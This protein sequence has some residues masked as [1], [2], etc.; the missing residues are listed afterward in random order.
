MAHVIL[1]AGLGFGDEGKGSMVDH[2]ART[3]KVGTPSSTLV[4][5]Y[6]GGAQAAHNVVTPDGKHHTFAQF[7]SATLA[8]AKTHLSRHMLIEPLSMMREAE[9]LRDLGVIDPFAKMTIEGEALVTNVY[10][11]LANRMRDA[12][13]G[14][15]RHGSCGLGVGETVADAL[16]QPNLALRAKDLFDETALRWKLEASFDRKREEFSDA[17]KELRGRFPILFDALAIDHIVDRYT[18]FAHHLGETGI[19]YSDFLRS[20]LR[21]DVTV[22]FEGAQGVLLDQDYGFFPHST[23]SDT[24]FGNALN[25]LEGFNGSVVKVGVLRGYHTRHGAG[26]LPTEFNA[27]A[28]HDAVP[29]YDVHN[30]HNEWQQDFRVGHF[31][32]VLAKYA[33]DVIGGVDEL[34]LT[35]LDRLTAPKICVGY[36]LADSTLVDRLPVQKRPVDLNVQE[37]LTRT[38]NNVEAAY[39]VVYASPKN[40]VQAIQDELGPVSLCSVGP[41]AVDKIPAAFY[42]NPVPVTLEARMKPWS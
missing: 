27:L 21:E 22:I 25:L 19:V 28:L 12:L 26:P 32:M 37:D 9:H 42:L 31:D 11:I 39:G 7:G 16:D 18:A 33:L 14:D 29:M 35:N 17:P 20:R 36:R 24:T 41:T 4:V 34:V 8:G 40:M 15:G 2:Y 5:R 38:L 30:Q 10:H 1:L 6:N 3:V 23:R 13:R